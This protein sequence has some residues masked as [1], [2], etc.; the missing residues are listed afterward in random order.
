M[1]CGFKAETSISGETIGLNLILLGVL[2]GVKFK[3]CKRLFRN[4]MCFHI[5][6]ITDGWTLNN[7]ISFLGII[8]CW[9][10]HDWNLHQ[11]VI[12]IV[13]LRGAHTGIKIADTCSKV[14]EDFGLCDKLLAI[15][16]DNATNMDKFFME[17]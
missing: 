13:Q 1:N 6:I 7:K 17:M 10:D 16:T 9:I 12:D 2:V 5:C 3:V 4:M 11:T 14:L 8:A 15:M